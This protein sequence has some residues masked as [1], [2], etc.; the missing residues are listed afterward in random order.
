MVADIDNDDG[1]AGAAM[2]CKPPLMVVDGLLEVSSRNGW[3][4]GFVWWL[5]RTVGSRVCVLVVCVWILRRRSGCQQ[6]LGRNQEVDRQ[7]S[8]GGRGGRARR[9]HV[10]DGRC[11]FRL[12]G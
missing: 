5:S 7:R 6:S 4:G 2:E 3:T 1:G 9:S 8:A 12:A 11:C 10:G